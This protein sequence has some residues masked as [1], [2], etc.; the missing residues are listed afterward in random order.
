[1]GRC[2]QQPRTTTLLGKE[3]AIYIKIIIFAVIAKVWQHVLVHVTSAP[4]E[5]KCTYH[6]GIARG[7]SNALLRFTTKACKGCTTTAC[8]CVS[9]QKHA[10]AFHNKGM[11]RLHNKGMQRLH[12]KGC[13]TKACTTKACTTK[14]CACVPQQRHAKAAQRRHAKAAQQRHALA[15]HNKGLRLLHKAPF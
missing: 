10:L 5:C 14:A 11:Q 13:T 1:M 3:N 2:I 7:L 9:Q 4:C 12:N 6:H 15:F 8:A